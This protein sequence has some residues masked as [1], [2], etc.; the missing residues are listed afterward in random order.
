MNN[1]ITLIACRTQ[2]MMFCLE[3]YVDLSRITIEMDNMELCM[4]ACIVR[5]YWLQIL[6][7]LCEWQ[8][9]VNISL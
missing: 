2:Y 3:A 5:Y 9:V 8:A 1:C 6:S 4:K 7:S